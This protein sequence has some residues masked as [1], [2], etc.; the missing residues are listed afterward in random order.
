M[1]TG[2]EYFVKGEA[3]EPSDLHWGYPADYLSERAN[4]EAKF[5]RILAHLE[6]YVAPGRLLDVGC[7]PG[8]LL[9][10]ARARG[11][12]VVGL[13]LN[14]WAAEYG[15]TELE[16][17]IRT[18]ELGAAGFGPEEFDAVTMMDLI[19]HVPD[20]EGLVAMAAG[21]VRPEGA[22]AVLTPDAGSPTSRMLGRRWPEVRRPGEHTVLFSVG[23]LEHLLTRHGFVPSGWH[24][25]GK[26]ATLETLVADV[27]AAAPAIGQRVRR[28]VA[29]TP[30][31][32]RTMEFDPRAKFCLY[33][34]RLPD[35]GLKL[36]DSGTRTAA[37]IPKDA[38]RL[39]SVDAAIISELESLGRARRYCD[40]MFDQFAQH[41]HGDVLEIGAGIGTFSERIL[42][43]DVAGL[44]ALEPD[45]ACAEVLERRFADDERV[46]VS[47]DALPAAPVLRGREGTFALAVCQNVLEHIAD[48][49]GTL[50]AIR[51]ALA[52]GGRAAL[53]VPAGPSMFGPLDDAYG[54]WRRYSLEGLREAVV[55]AGFEIEDLRPVNALGL[56]GWWAKNLRPGARIGDGSLRA[57]ESLLTAWRPLE[58]RLRLRRGLSLV[59][60]GRNP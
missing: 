27:T 21:L 20:P 53:V 9:T 26:T 8:F 47:R 30:L 29:S 56:P 31:G 16:L 33:A 1:Y 51:T 40:W 5:E 3:D 49:V 57:Y 28:L 24:S 50:Q 14:P 34:R 55:A 25:V 35:G 60:V 46:E 17:D 4:V 18:G 39:A 58:E 23:G 13:D 43:R 54:H 52:P 6:R 44:L 2:A 59:C 36:P 32:Q 22:L 11:W 10:A 37:R 38:A 41:V 42:S 15:R 45:P 48:D 19:E 7:G 12:E